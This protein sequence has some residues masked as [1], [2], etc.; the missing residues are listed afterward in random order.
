MHLNLLAFIGVA[1]LIT[2]TPG[3]D[4]AV[5]TR[6]TLVHGRRTA[7]LASLGI[8]NGLLC[9]ALASALGLAAL[10]HASATAFTALK[11][12]GAAYL[13]WLGIQ[14]WW[15]GRRHGPRAEGDGAQA[16]A[17]A[18]TLGSAAA[19]RQGL[20]SNLLNPKVG[21]FYSTFLPQFI[22]PGDPVLATSLLLAGIH[23]VMG[24]VWLFSYAAMVARAGDVL[25]RPRVKAAIERLTGAVLI[26]FGLRLGLER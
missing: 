5:V 3:A 12:I 22:T 6:I 1:T 25:R 18:G 21:V 19:Y 10:L 13:I 20:L 16:T 9:W 15:V 8:V 11:V 24:V 2:T 7:W 4:M 23:I 14:S 17:T 26:A